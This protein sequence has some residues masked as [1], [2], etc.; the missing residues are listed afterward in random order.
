MQSLKRHEPNDDPGRVNVGM[1]DVKLI[2]GV[3]WDE[4][5][6]EPKSVLGP[7]ILIVLLGRRHGV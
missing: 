6:D 5:L 2:E 3:G 1:S 7:I 4:S